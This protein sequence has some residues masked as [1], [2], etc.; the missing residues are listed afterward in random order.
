[1]R[2]IDGEEL[3]KMFREMANTEDSKN[4]RTWWSE[5][6]ISA[7]EDVDNAPTVE[8]KNDVSKCHKNCGSIVVC[9]DGIENVA[10]MGGIKADTLRGEPNMKVKFQGEVYEVIDHPGEY[11]VLKFEDRA[12]VVPAN[13]CTEVKDEKPKAA[14]KKKDA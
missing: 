2:L 10:A 3:A 14:K 7:A 11:F 12:H 6:L 1:M 13:E 5:A 4:N 8:P 9:Q